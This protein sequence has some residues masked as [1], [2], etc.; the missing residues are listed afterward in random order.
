MYLGFIALGI[1]RLWLTFEANKRK[2]LIE[3]QMPMLLS[4]LRNEMSAGL[5]INTAFPNV[6]KDFPNP[7]GDELR[8]V[9]A[10]VEV[11]ISLQ[12]ALSSLAERV[13]S[14]LMQFLVASLNIGISSGSDL[15]PQLHTLE[16][17]VRGRSRIEGKIRSAVA[18]VKPTAYIAEAA[19]ILMFAWESFSDPKYLPYFFGPGLLELLIATL[20]YAGGIFILQY[21]IKNVEKV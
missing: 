17:I 21:M 3:T 8:K 7:L 13:P 20:M 5:N 15:V 1:G 12:R 2:G 4:G 11:G 19:P 14:S 9:Q 16:D 10:D 18:L 6:A